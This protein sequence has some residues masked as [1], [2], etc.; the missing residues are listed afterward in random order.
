M[1]AELIPPPARHFFRQKKNIPGYQDVLKKTWVLDNLGLVGIK[2]SQYRQLRY[3]AGRSCI[4]MC[5]LE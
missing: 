2:N 1:R 4:N 5:I 3:V